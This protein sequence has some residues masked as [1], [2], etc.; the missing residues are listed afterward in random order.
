MS[1]L[2]H[3]VSCP[4]GSSRI[5]FP[6]SCSPPH[7]RKPDPATAASFFMFADKWEKIRSIT[8]HIGSVL[9]SE[10]LRSWSLT[11][12]SH[13]AAVSQKCWGGG[14][15]EANLYQGSQ[16]ATWP[17]FLAHLMP[18]CFP[19]A[20]SPGEEHMAQNMNLQSRKCIHLVL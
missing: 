16:S 5:L 10:G 15:M 6:V 4:C 11:P 18:I 20:P 19:S 17:P 1:Q 9:N 13:V 14:L 8:G 3:N 12:A 7:A 2:G